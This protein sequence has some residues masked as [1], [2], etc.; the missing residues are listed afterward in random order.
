[1]MQQSTDRLNRYRADFVFSAISVKHHAVAMSGLRLTCAIFVGLCV[2][3]VYASAS[4]LK[5]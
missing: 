2:F 3:G 1:M 5:K 4:R